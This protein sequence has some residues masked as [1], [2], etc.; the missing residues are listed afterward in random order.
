VLFNLKQVLFAIRWSNEFSQSYQFWLVNLVNDCFFYFLRK[1]EPEYAYH[2]L[3]MAEFY[4]KQMTTKN[5]QQPQDFKHL[6]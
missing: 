5:V 6:A 1:A 2:C 3:Q 4:F